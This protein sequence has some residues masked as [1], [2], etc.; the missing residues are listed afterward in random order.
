MSVEQQVVGLDDAVGAL[1]ELVAAR[2]PDLDPDAMGADTQLDE[3]GLD[4]LDVAE[5]VMSLEQRT[6][7]FLDATS[8]DRIVTVADLTRLQPLPG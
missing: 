3:L 8:V 7:A 2:R 5:L 6:G 1:R 4:S